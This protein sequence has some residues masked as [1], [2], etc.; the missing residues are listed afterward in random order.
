MNHS[1]PGKP[2]HVLCAMIML[3]FVNMLHAQPFQLQTQYARIGV[4]GKGFITSIKDIKTGKEFCPNGMSSALM[5]LNINNTQY[6]LPQKAAYN[7]AR[8]EISLTYPNGSEAKIKID[9]KQQYLHFQLLSLSNSSA[10]D[11]IVWGPYKTTISKL[12]GDVLG[13]VRNDDFAIGMLGLDDNTTG[14]PPTGGDMSFMYYFIH[15]PDPKK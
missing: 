13:V 14:G 3:L 10:I 5:S 12:I 9:Q 2:G 8:K 4:D 11:N 6:I 1:I 15:S 7:A